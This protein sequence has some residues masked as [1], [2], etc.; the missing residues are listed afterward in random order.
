VAHGS[1]RAGCPLKLLP[2]TATSAPPGCATASEFPAHLSSPEHLLL[3]A[4]TRSSSRTTAGTPTP[5]L[6]VGGS[7]SW[8]L[9]LELHAARRCKLA[10][11]PA[12]GV[13]QLQGGDLQEAPRVG[14][15]GLPPNRPCPKPP[16]AEDTNYHFDVN[17]DHLEPALDRWGAA[18]RG[19]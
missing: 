12:P 9:P 8:Q 11:V 19:R 5:S 4:G 13:L 16:A 3:P 10:L 2:A 14:A 15:P 18:G 6:Q 7:H 17:W 1:W